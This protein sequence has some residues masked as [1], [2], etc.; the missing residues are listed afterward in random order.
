M[1]IISDDPKKPQ[2]KNKPTIVT[3]AVD[4]FSTAVKTLFLFQ[5]GSKLLR[6]SAVA[7][8]FFM[9]VIAV[10][11]AITEGV[12]W[13]KALSLVLPSHYSLV[14]IAA[15]VMIGLVI[16]MLDATFITLDTSPN[17][18]RN[19][20]SL[21]Q[22]KKQQEL[23][24][25]PRWAAV[26]VN[27]YQKTVSIVFTKTTA[28]VVFRLA[29]V[30]VSMVV[31]APFL[32]ESFDERRVLD[33]IARKNQ[34]A[35]AEYKA[36]LLKKSQNLETDYNQKINILRQSLTEETAGQGP[37]KKFGPGPVTKKIEAQIIDLTKE[38]NDR[39]ANELLR[40][41]AI[42]T[43]K[44][45][46]IEIA[47]RHPEI[48]L[49]TDN[50]DTRKKIRNQLTDPD[51]AKILGIPAAT[52]LSSAIF[53]LLFVAM[54]TFKLFE[55]KSIK[56]YYDDFLQEE[57][58]RY[59]A[60]VFDDLPSVVLHPMEHHDAPGVMRGLKF[61]D[62]YTG[63]YT[64]YQEQTALTAE[65]IKLEEERERL[66]R[67]RQEQL[68]QEAL[69]RKRQEA[70]EAR[71]REREAERQ[72]REYE[73]SQAARERQ[74]AE[75]AQ[76]LKLAAQRK[77]RE[78]QETL[79]ELS[80]NTSRREAERADQAQNV[81]ADKALEARIRQED[82]Q[83]RQ[84]KKSVDEQIL[85]EMRAQQQD[86]EKRRDA[87]RSELSDVRVLI[88]QLTKKLMEARQQEENENQYI[89]EAE[90]AIST[91]VKKALKADMDNIKNAQHA[92]TISR[93]LAEQE[94]RN[95]ESALGYTKSELEAIAA[96]EG[97][98]F[99]ANLYTKKD[100]PK[101]KKIFNKLNEEQIKFAQIKA[102][103]I[104]IN[105]NINKLDNNFA[106]LQQAYNLPVDF[107]AG[108]YSESNPQLKDLYD[109]RLTHILMR[110]KQEQEIVDLSRKKTDSEKEERRFSLE[111]DMEWNNYAELQAAILKKE[112]EIREKYYQ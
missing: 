80:R 107:T 82:E 108:R 74:D 64:K 78:L 45:T 6:P 105:N 17:A 9:W 75:E 69:A 33:E 43:T 21:R 12:T 36:S 26:L 95:I 59:L 68:E 1:T 66:A 52:V 10:S 47:Q 86:S 62:W 60:G 34:L 58:I 29:I 72:K 19:D 88:A 44:N 32:A 50:I 99:G 61:Y 70:E 39:L 16:W 90:E 56:I 18:K 85:A 98:I 55:P 49:L 67:Q 73:E 35:I 89:K 7:W 24:S 2:I 20:V 104:E 23:I 5:Y 27:L 53:G 41:D 28:G 112:R 91:L 30:A 106:S 38:R 76:E 84:S 48:Q 102:S 110:D 94:I 3:K 54:L 103:I 37:S 46:P 65:K 4:F 109:Q 87:K 71:E 14:P 93:E 57:Y 96:A 83:E 42:D 77:E 51:Q 111:L 92:A 8:I 31:T 81:A 25:T 63:A 40:I 22:D 11:M 13:Y 15:G 101:Y 79:A 100:D 97:D